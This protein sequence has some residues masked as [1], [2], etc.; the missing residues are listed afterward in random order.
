VPKKL[1][2][3]NLKIVEGLAAYGPRNISMVARELGLPLEMVR[4]RIKRMRSQNTLWLHANIYHTYLGLRKAVV[5]AEAVLGYENFLPNFFRTND[6]WMYTTRCYGRIEGCLGVYTIPKEHCN[7]FENFAAR[8]EELGV[9]KNTRIFWS[10]CFQK[11]NPTTNWFDSKSQEWLFSWNDWI[12]EIPAEGTK[13]PFTL[14]DPHEYPI[15]GDY[16]DVFILKEM[17]KDATIDF[18]D[19][20]KKLGMTPQGIKYHYQEHVVK[21][22][23]LE[24]FE[25]EMLP[26][27]ESISD[28]Y[29][30]FFEF[31]DMEKMAKFALSLMAKPFVFILGKILGRPGMLAQ[32]YLP[33]KELKNLKD[34]L[35]TL[36]RRGFLQSYEYV[37]QHSGE[38]SRQTISYEFFEKESW[39]YDHERHIRALEALVK[40]SR[41]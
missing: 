21:Q 39:V 33:R 26:Y 10:S 13:L 40:S 23:L 29:F 38:W 5:T 3:T 14:Q 4:R 9:A 18:A 11:V 20:A 25:I 31:P 16:V 36:V 27:D 34:C 7:D 15:K 32:M 2:Y 1:D 37:I 22:G 19:I 24:N 41:F 6:F 17:E 35:S 12:E 8:L 28:F 30:F